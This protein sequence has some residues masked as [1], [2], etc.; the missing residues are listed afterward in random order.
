MAIYK[1]IEP[2]VKKAQYVLSENKDEIYADK[3]YREAF[4]ICIEAIQKLP[5][6]DVQEV[7]YCRDCENFIELFNGAFCDEYGGYVEEKDFCS[8]GTFNCGAKMD[9]KDDE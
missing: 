9:G 1:D 5:T 3:Y 6:A 2:F 8:R 7:R 4:E